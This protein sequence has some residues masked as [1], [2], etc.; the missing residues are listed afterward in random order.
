[1]KIIDLRNTQ[2]Q[3][4]VADVLLSPRS[5]FAVSIPVLECDVNELIHYVNYDL[6][7]DAIADPRTSIE[8]EMDMLEKEWK[9]T[10]QSL[11]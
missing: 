7:H 3:G 5:I 11:M 4:W 10:H 2:S 6:Q 1:M 9:E 8:V